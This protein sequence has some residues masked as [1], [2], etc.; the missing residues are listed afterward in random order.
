MPED[1]RRPLGNEWSKRKARKTLAVLRDPASIP[2]RSLETEERTLALRV[3]RANTPVARLVSRHSRDLLRAYYKAGRLSTR[4]ADRDVVDRFVDMSPAERALYDD[5]ERYISEIYNQAS[6]QEKNAVGF[7]LTIYHKRLASSF[8]AL[9]KTLESHLAVL[10]GNAGPPPGGASLL[11]DDDW[12]DDDEPLGE[13][14]DHD[15]V[16]NLERQVLDRVEKGGI[17][18]L[19]SAIRALPPDTKLERLLAELAAL[20]AD[21]YR[22][23]M[24]FTG[25]TPTPWTSCVIMWLLTRT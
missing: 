5:V 13:A 17:A 8:H 2:Q 6:R 21:S 23:A 16:A 20:L 24:M 7:V 10:T 4:I 11:G 19:L 25:Y 14:S 22:Q 3:M 1:L 15:E 18:C 12:S 9:R